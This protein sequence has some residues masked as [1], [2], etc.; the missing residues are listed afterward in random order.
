MAISSQTQYNNII[1]R[2]QAQALPVPKSTPSLIGS[3][4]TPTT[5]LASLTLKNNVTGKVINFP[6]NRVS[7]RAYEFKRRCR[8]LEITASGKKL[9]L[10]FV[11]F[12]LRNES[13]SAVTSELSRALEGLHKYF[14]DA[15]LPFYY[16]WVIE[17][18][19]KRYYKHGVKAMHWHIAVAVPD[20]S[21]PD[22]QFIKKAPP[23]H[24]IKVRS[25]G[26]VVTTSE[27]FKRWGNGLVFSTKA[28]SGVFGYLGKYMSKELES[29]TEYGDHFRR[30]GSSQFGILAYPEWARVALDELASHGAEIWDCHTTR[31]PGSVTLY[32]D[33]VTANYV[34]KGYKRLKKKSGGYRTVRN[35]CL[36]KT[37]QAVMYA[38]IDGDDLLQYREKVCTLRSPWAVTNET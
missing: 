30:F 27:L 21:L 23:K 31:S 38:R 29:Y 18:G 8:A 17:L 13:A 14:K 7:R 28:W 5:R 6:A 33:K 19:K 16:V 3:S 1:L 20:G 34:D 4:I 15:H 37:A 12:T 36:N 11:T 35:I 10:Y 24:H 32:Q 9:A 22:C 2:Q 26:N 25:Q